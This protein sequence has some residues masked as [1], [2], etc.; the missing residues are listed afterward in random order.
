MPIADAIWFT[1]VFILNK[2]SLSVNLR[3]QSLHQYLGTPILR[4]ELHHIARTAMLAP[5][6]SHYHLDNSPLDAVAKG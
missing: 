3:L 2:V 4:T 1:G 5:D 6:I